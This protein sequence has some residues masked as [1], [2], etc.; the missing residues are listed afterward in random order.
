[1]TYKQPG[2]VN[3]TFEVATTTDIYGFMGDF[4]WDVET[5]TPWITLTKQ[6]PEPTL[7]GYNFTPPRPRQFQT[8]TL[9]VNPAGIVRL[10][11]K[12][13]LRP[14]AD[15]DWD[16]TFTRIAI[17]EDDHDLPPELQGKAGQ[18][19]VLEEVES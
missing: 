10:N 4:L 6:N 8:F 12:G 9:T 18:K 1:M 14:G 2:V 15:A 3:K 5:T 11:N 19:L 16:F 7:Q 13:S 17:T